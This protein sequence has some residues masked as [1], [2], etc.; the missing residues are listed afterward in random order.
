MFAKL[1]NLPIFA[2]DTNL[3][4]TMT[5]A[6]QLRTTKSAK[7]EEVP[8][9]IR[10]VDGREWFFRNRTRVMVRPDWWDSKNEEIK[11]R[12]VCPEEERRKV[13]CEIENLRIYVRKAYEE[14]KARG[15]IKKGW[16]EKAL[17]DY[18]AGKERG[19]KKRVKKGD[20][21]EVLFDKF[22]EGRDAKLSRTK[23]YRVLERILLRYVEYIRLSRPRQSKYVLDVKALTTEDLNAIYDYTVNE[24][25][26]VKEYPAIL[27]AQPETRQINQR[28]GNTITGIFKNLRAFINWCQKEG[29]LS[30]NPFIGFEKGEGERYG[31]PIYLTREELKQLYQADFSD[32]PALEVQRDIFVFQCNVGCRVGDMM[33]L[34]KQDIINGTIEYIPNKTIKE[35][36]KTV[37]VP[38]NAMAKAIVEK[39]KDCP[40]ESLLP[41]IA[42][43][44]YNYAIKDAL[45]KAG[46][47]RL[48]TTLNQLTRTEEKRPIYEVASSHMARRTF[49]GN[50]Y[51][52]VRD[53]RLVSSLTGHSDGSRAFTRYRNIDIDMKQDLVNILD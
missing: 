34:T 29:Y 30:N 46:I 9:Y 44:N 21:L 47:T 15:R 6:F 19:A 53:Q 16:L 28:G 49:I 25:K 35:S 38:L 11:K 48:V 12:I 7:T 43:Q 26:I 3:V 41:F 27:E 23:H 18:Y 45:K 5:I 37:V 14:D 13:D 33:R 39:Y 36:A 52:Q 4:S 2:V 22:L 42:S 1:A 10:V 32:N 40:G 31:T 20:T 51:K 8:I 24:Y 17:Q 50:I